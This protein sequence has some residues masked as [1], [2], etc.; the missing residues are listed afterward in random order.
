MRG[1]YFA[2]ICEMNSDLTLEKVNG[3]LRKNNFNHTTLFD[4][5]FWMPKQF[6]TDQFI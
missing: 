6:V 3:V 4:H 2:A 5:L 1:I